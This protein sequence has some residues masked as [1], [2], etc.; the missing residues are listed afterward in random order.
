LICLVGTSNKEKPTYHI[1]YQTFYDILSQ[2]DRKIAVRSTLD[3]TRRVT[4]HTMSGM[5]APIRALHSNLIG[6]QVLGLLTAGV[7]C[8]SFCHLITIM[9][10]ATEEIE[11]H[12]WRLSYC[13]SLGALVTIKWEISTTSNP[14]RRKT[15]MVGRSRSVPRPGVLTDVRYLHGNLSKGK[16]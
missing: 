12:H 4:H 6:I 7:V 1:L 5:S 3:F 11:V 9:G 8:C 13:Y 15:M 14:D 2:F 16:R 10:K